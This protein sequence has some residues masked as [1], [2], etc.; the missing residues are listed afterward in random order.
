MIYIASV[1]V[2]LERETIAERVRDNMIELAKNGNW[3]GGTPPLGYSRKRETCYDENGNEKAISFLL[4]EPEEAKLVKIIHETY[5]KLGPI[6]QAERYLMNNNVCFP[7]IYCY[8]IKP[9]LFIFSLL[10][11]NAIPVFILL[12]FNFS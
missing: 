4:Q 3:L 12:K 10:I 11:N 7:S 2:Q 9:L 5:L 6:H 1:F 8:S